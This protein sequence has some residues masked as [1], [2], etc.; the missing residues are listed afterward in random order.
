MTL[1]SAPETTAL[2]SEDECGGFA[3]RVM[4]LEPDWIKRS[5][6][7]SFAT[8]GAAAYLDA[9]PRNG[10]SAQRYAALAERYNAV[11][12][13]Y[14]GDLHERVRA[15]ICALLGEPVR[16]AEEFA[17]P[18]FHIFRAA[19]IPGPGNEASIHVDLQYG[20]LEHSRYGK[21]DFGAFVSFTLPLRL[22]ARG[23]GLNV[24]DVTRDAL[25]TRFLAGEERNVTKAVAGLEPRF[26]PYRIGEL[27]LHSG[28]TVHQ[29]ANVPSVT[30]GDA[31]TTLQG[32]GVRYAGGWVLYW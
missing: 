9:S 10:G 1:P 3:R 26:Q 4:E 23:G 19:A 15:A 2:L 8:L 30:A 12:T 17:L 22:P 32:H 18:G 28:H 7:G 13:R 20:A 5:P 24:W 14:F 27:V 29:I 21:P 11:L 16:L 31:R 6:D 25:V